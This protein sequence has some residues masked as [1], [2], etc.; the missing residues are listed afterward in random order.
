MPKR[1]DAGRYLKKNFKQIIVWTMIVI[2]LGTMIPS[3]FIMFMSQ[4]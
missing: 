1:F 4:Q 2:F 3:T